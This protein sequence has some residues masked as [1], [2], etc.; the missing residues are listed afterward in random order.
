MYRSN[1][2][3]G[4]TQTLDQSI[5]DGGKTCLQYRQTISINSLSIQSY[6]T[7]LP[8][9]AQISTSLEIV[10][11][12]IERW[13]VLSQRTALSSL[14]LHGEGPGVWISVVRRRYQE[15]KGNRLPF[16][17]SKQKLRGSQGVDRLSGLF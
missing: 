10:C 2:R 15:L 14:E 6:N 7:G 3:R 9:C 13:L 1:N 5:R 16:I 11:V 8:N 12:A 17:L 4:S